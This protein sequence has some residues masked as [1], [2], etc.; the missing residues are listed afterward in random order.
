MLLRAEET[1]N[2][3]IFFDRFLTASKNQFYLAL[4]YSLSC[5]MAGDISVDGK[6]ASC[7]LRFSFMRQFGAN[8]SASL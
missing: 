8:V 3:K 6:S 5:L 1:L 4:I 2:F 7:N